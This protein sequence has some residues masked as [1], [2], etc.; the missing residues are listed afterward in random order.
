[1]ANF[2]RSKPKFKPQPKVLVICEDSKSSKH[3]LD[4]A[5]YQLRSFVEVKITHCGNTDPKGIV[6]EAK[7]QQ[8][9]F[10]RVYC[11]IDR[12]THKNFDEAVNSAQSTEKVKLIVSYPCFEFWLLLHFCYS[13]KPYTA[14]GKDSPADCLITDLRKCAGMENY[15]KGDDKNLFNFLLDKGFTDA[16]IRSPKIL[17][18]AQKS[19]EMNPSTQ[20]HEL[21]DY[22]EV[23]SQPQPTATNKLK[24]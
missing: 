10:D 1:M 3:Y 20:L 11:V 4:D 22:F 21:M 8:K 12:D 6:E 13:R 16:R 17:A 19:G 2:N 23:L 18:E 7:S 5:N 15:A 9:N 24:H 14:I